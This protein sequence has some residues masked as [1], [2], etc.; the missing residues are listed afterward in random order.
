MGQ[1]LENW[2]WTTGADGHRVLQC[3]DF[4][5]FQMREDLIVTNKNTQQNPVYTVNKALCRQIKIKAPLLI[6]GFRLIS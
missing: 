4:Y 3:A 1:W 2:L 6:T 5:N